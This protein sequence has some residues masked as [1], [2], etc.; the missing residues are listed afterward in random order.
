MALI[1][2]PEC[3]KE[4]SDKSNTCPQCG[5][6]LQNQQE[7]PHAVEVVGF[8]TKLSSSK[9]KNYFFI[10]GIVIIFVTIV[11]ISSKY[12]SKQK[13]LENL[14]A[15]SYTMYLGASEA[16]SLCNLTAEVWYNSI[17]KNSDTATDKYTRNNYGK[18]SFFDDFNFAISKLFQDKATKERMETISASQ[19]AASLMMKDLQNPPKEYTQ[20]Y[21]TITELYSAFQG[22]TDLALNPKGNYSSFSSSKNEYVDDFI[23]YYEKLKTQM[24]D[25]PSK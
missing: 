11:L 2:C 13:Y 23:K 9:L 1:Y 5:Y 25:T 18:G 8:K 16:E 20:C 4:I 12:F 21:D 24:P 19:T 14:Q 10:A 17:Y 7:Q 3:G 6:P 22:L 15:T